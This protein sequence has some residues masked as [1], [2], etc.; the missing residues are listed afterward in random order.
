VKKWIVSIVLC[1]S[2]FQAIYYTAAAAEEGRVTPEHMEIFPVQGGLSPKRVLKSLKLGYTQEE[3]Q[4]AVVVK[5]LHDE[6]ELAAYAALIQGCEELG[7]STD[8]ITEEQSFRL[9]HKYVKASAHKVMNGPDGY[10]SLRGKHLNFE[11]Q[12]QPILDKVS[13]IVHDRDRRLTN[14]VYTS[15]TKLIFALDSHNSLVN[16]IIFKAWGYPLSEARDHLSEIKEKAKFYGKL[17]A[18]VHFD[19]SDALARENDRY[20]RTRIFSHVQFHEKYGKTFFGFL[21]GSEAYLSFQ[22]SEEDTRT[23]YARDLNQPLSEILDGKEKDFLVSNGLVNLET[24]TTV[25]AFFLEFYPEI[26][27]PEA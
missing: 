4:A 25:R 14:G 7:I 8:A 21:L 13:W 6:V 3:I 19:V 9:L 15:L 24:P 12:I 2:A 27:L 10:M 11:K 22:D 17:N 26:I 1:C 20:N 5:G 18:I 23:V 16:H